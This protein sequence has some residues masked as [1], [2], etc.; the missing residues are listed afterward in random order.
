M[1]LYAG[2]ENS[3]VVQSVLQPC[4]GGAYDGSRCPAL[5]DAAR[6]VVELAVGTEW[7]GAASASSSTRRVV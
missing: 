6:K 4:Y 7:M 2:R 1:M 5:P 3:A